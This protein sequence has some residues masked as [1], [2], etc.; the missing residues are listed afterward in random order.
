MV[1]KI[2]G[3][4]YIPLRKKKLSEMS[5]KPRLTVFGK[6][7]KKVLRMVGGEMKTVTLS[8]ETA[9]VTDPK[10]KKTQ[11]SKIKSVVKSPANRYF[12]NIIVKGTIIETELGTAK[13]TNRPGQEGNVAAVRISE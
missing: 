10:T 13:V 3:G 1:R 11:K 6:D 7:K 8:C 2:S 4:K 12:K 5:G 9:F